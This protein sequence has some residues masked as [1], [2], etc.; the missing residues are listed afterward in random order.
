MKLSLRNKSWAKIAFEFLSIFL[1][2]ISAFA[3]NNWNDDRKDRISERNI[4][5]EISNGL[6]KDLED[7]KINKYGHEMGVK[8]CYYFSK[9]VKNDSVSMDSL[10]SYLV[11]VTRDYVSIQNTAGYESMK[12]K[13]LEI[14]EN[15]SLRLKIIQLYEFEYQILAK[16][17]EDYA[18]QQFHKSYSEKINDYLAPN[19]HFGKTM[20]SL[21][22]TLPIISSET[23]KSKMRIYLWKI[24]YNRAYMVYYYGEVI[25][26]LNALKHQ[27]DEELKIL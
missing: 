24:I 18:E 10:A 22:L 25:T 6:D 1:A 3:L 15:D 20:T 27:I 12:S 13:G 11:A 2:V 5:I 19:L 4:L 17:E 23:E 21:S 9:I 16:L 8:A 14:I 26:K 7:L